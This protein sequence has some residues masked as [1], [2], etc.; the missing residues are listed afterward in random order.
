MPAC[1]AAGEYLM[2]V[3]LIGMNTLPCFLLVINAAA[4]LFSSSS[5]SLRHEWCPILHV[6]SSPPQNFLPCTIIDGISCANI[7]VTGSGTT[8]GTATVKFPGAYTATDPQ[9]PIPKILNICT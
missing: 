3:E 4:D 8:L 9:V 1:I 2:R 6:V 7:K 5:F